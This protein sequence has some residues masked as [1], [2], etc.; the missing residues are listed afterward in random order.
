MK[1]FEKFTFQDFPYNKFLYPDFK[2]AIE[3]EED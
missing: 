1:Q 2:D 3:K